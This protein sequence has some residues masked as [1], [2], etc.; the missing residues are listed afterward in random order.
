MMPVAFYCATRGGGGTRGRRQQWQCQHF[1]ACF[2]WGLRQALSWARDKEFLSALEALCSKKAGALLWNAKPC[3]TWDFSPKMLAGET[4]L[5]SGLVPVLCALTPCLGS[6]SSPHSLPALG[7]PC[8]W[9]FLLPSRFVI[10]TFRYGW[11]ADRELHHCTPRADSIWCLPA[12]QNFIITG[13]PKL[14]SSAKGRVPMPYTRESSPLNF[15]GK[16]AWNCLLPCL[17]ILLRIFVVQGTLKWSATA[18]VF[19]RKMW[20]L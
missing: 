11:T 7:S 20:L 9:A 14:K 1:A 15:S 3:R 19:S 12:R 18:E 5:P 4:G 2:F 8:L 17:F 13:G 10:V 6:C 16:M